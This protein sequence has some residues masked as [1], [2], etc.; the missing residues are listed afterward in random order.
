ML[1]SVYLCVNYVAFESSHPCISSQFGVVLR[2]GELIC[3]FQK[4]VIQEICR[5]SVIYTDIH[6]YTLSVYSREI[7]SQGHGSSLADYRWAWQ[8]QKLEL[9]QVE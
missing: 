6:L 2:E 8:V 1:M 4:A 7:G 3:K 5:K 9:G